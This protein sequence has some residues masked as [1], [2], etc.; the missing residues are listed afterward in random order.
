MPVHE[1]GGVGRER[2]VV[3][4]VEEDGQ[5]GK[6]LHRV[7]IAQGLVEV[8]IEGEAAHAGTLQWQAKRE[9]A[10]VGDCRAVQRHGVVRRISVYEIHLIIMVQ[11]TDVPTK[12]CRGLRQRGCGCAKQK[13]GKYKS[14]HD[15]K[16]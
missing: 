5:T 12:H 13:G 15:Y 4:A 9:T 14:F 3:A 2:D 6:P 11:A 8:L 16:N 10:V 1:S 7:T